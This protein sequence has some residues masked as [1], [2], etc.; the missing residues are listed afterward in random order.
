MF[1]DI[2][3]SRQDM[4]AGESSGSLKSS[5]VVAKVKEISHNYAGTGHFF[6][7]DAHKLWCFQGGWWKCS[8][9]AGNSDKK[10]RCVS[11]GV[12]YSFN[13]YVQSRD[14]WNG[15]L[16]KLH[17][18]RVLDIN[19]CHSVHMPGCTAISEKDHEL[20]GGGGQRRYSQ[21]EWNSNLCW[22]Q[23]PSWSVFSCQ[24]RCEEKSTKLKQK[25]Y[26]CRTNLMT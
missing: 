20:E 16:Q 23:W 25:L 7:L 6:N 22:S 10:R 8:R 11:A 17:F 13:V 5:Q 26:W 15:I 19:S 3:T 1:S 14:K 9:Y 24:F 4:A 21:R 12:V 2:S 18:F